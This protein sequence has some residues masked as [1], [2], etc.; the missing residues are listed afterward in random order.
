MRVAVFEQGFTDSTKDA[1]LKKDALY[2]VL[3]D[4]YIALVSFE[5]KAYE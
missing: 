4:S 3:P 2:L 5:R 1:G